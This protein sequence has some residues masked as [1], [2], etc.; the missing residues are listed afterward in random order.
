ML[1]LAR[2]GNGIVCDLPL[3]QTTVFIDDVPKPPDGWVIVKTDDLGEELP[4]E[5][6]GYMRFTISKEQA[7][8]IALVQGFKI[9]VDPVF[10]SDAAAAMAAGGNQ[11][12]TKVPS[13]LCLATSSEMQRFVEPVI[14]DDVSAPPRCPLHANARA[15]AESTC[16]SRL[17]PLADID[18]GCWQGE[19]VGAVCDDRHSGDSFRRDMMEIISDPNDF[20]SWKAICREPTTRERT[21]EDVVEDDDAALEDVL[22]D[23]YAGSAAQQRLLQKQQEKAARRNVNTSGAAELTMEYVDPRFNGFKMSEWEPFDW[24]AHGIDTPVVGQKIV[25]MFVRRSIRRPFDVDRAA[26]KKL[27]MMGRIMLC[28]LHGSMRTAESNDNR[29]FRVRMQAQQYAPH[30]HG[31]AHRNDYCDSLPPLAAP[32]LDRANPPTQ[33]YREVFIKGDWRAKVVEVEYNQ[34]IAKIPGIRKIYVESLKSDQ[35]KKSV[36][37]ASCDGN[38]AINLIKDINKMRHVNFRA[39]YDGWMAIAHEQAALPYDTQTVDHFP[40]LYVQV[41]PN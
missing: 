36:G 24:K 39:L 23:S 6:R 7:D 18:A 4:L 15:H 14:I 34:R 5:R 29:M 12:S 38:G 17:Q 27:D 1:L 2:K 32:F 25:L 8:T 11:F 16:A 21:E 26:W 22:P 40:S 35:S 37:G 28:V 31:N 10:A 19:T 30:A 13:M 20:E 33:V 41:A 9:G 3:R